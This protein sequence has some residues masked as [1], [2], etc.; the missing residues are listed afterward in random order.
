MLISIQ[1]IN[2]SGKALKVGKHEKFNKQSEHKGYNI[3]QL[4]TV[5]NLI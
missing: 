3:K 1:F 5:M 4:M 2:K